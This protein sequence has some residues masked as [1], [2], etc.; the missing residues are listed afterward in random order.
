MKGKY[1]IGKRGKKRR[2]IKQIGKCAREGCKPPSH[3]TLGTWAGEYQ[4]WEGLIRGGEERE[5]ILF[6]ARGLCGE[7]CY[8]LLCSYMCYMLLASMYNC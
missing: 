3:E 8:V 1:E 4:T 6:R 5:D 7:V 2:R